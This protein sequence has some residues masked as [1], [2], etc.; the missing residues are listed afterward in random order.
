MDAIFN[1]KSIRKYT[2]AKIS[3]ESVETL[4]RAGMQAPSAGNAQPWQF[5]ILRDQARLSGI[6]AFH[7]YAKMLH[8]CDVAIVVCGDES[9]ERFKGYWVQDCSAASQNI[10]LAAQDLG[11]GA[12]WLGIY[13]M[14]DRVEALKQ[15]LGL[16]ESVIPLSIIPI[17]VPDEERPSVERFNK[18]RVHYE[19]W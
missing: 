4:L 3:D 10:L 11:L 9:L 5:V 15:Y 19:V 7:P 14:Q 18:E 2:D 17:G 6:T 13:P 12:V 1:R 8:H 16:P